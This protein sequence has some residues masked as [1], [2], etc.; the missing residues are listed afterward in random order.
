MTPTQSD[1]RLVNEGVAL[2]PVPSGS[3]E[4]PEPVRIRP[5]AGWRAVD[6][7]E[8]WRYRELLW[9]LA[10]R[11]IQLRYKQTVLGVAWAVIQPLFTMIVFS[12]IFGNFANIPSDGFPYAV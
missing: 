3:G 12:I 8:L 4:R 6:L 1:Q 9:F 2:R 11:D 10:L 5:S 7:R